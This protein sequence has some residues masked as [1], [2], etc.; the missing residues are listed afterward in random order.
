[1]V[2]NDKVLVLDIDGTITIESSYLGDYSGVKVNQEFL[3]KIIELK[4]DGF[5]IILYTSRNMQTYQGNVG[6]ILA[7][8]APILIKWL[9]EN[10]I[11]F[12]E[13]HFGKPWCGNSGFYVDDKAIRPKE[14]LNNTIPEIFEILKR[15]KF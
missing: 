7:N 12:D 2:K 13:L 4:R 8:T 1:M 15:D 6:M 9:N 14:F 5:W 11:P 10:N 3:D